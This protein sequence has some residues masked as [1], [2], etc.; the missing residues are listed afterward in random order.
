MKKQATKRLIVISLLAA[1]IAAGV[2]LYVQLRTDNQ[3]VVNLNDVNYSPPTDEER[4]AGNSKKQE[5]ADREEKTQGG[6]E[7][8]TTEV[9]ITDAGQYDNMIEVRAFMPSAYKDGSC[10]LIFS[11]GSKTFS[12]TTPAFKDVS[13]TNCTNPEVPRSEFA[14]AG[15]WSVKVSYS[16]EGITGQ[17]EEKVFEVK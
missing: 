16:A 11:K 8:T 15:D 12:K 9:I 17:S 7:S 3:E 2:F 14:E 4:Q 5:I 1:V 13:T 10:E 6:Q